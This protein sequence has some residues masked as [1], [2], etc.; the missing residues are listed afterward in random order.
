MLKIILMISVSIISIGLV[1]I[2]LA[3]SL[4]HSVLGQV[5]GVCLLCIFAY[6]Y[7]FIWFP[8]ALNKS[9]SLQLAVRIIYAA[10]D[11]AILEPS[12][13]YRVKTELNHSLKILSVVLDKNLHTIRNFNI[14]K[15]I[16][17]SSLEEAWR[18]FFLEAFSLIEKEIEDQAIQSW[19]FNK[20]RNKLNHDDC[21]RQVKMI[22]QP[23]LK[24]SKFF[25]LVEQ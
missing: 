5:T 18:Q 12:L 24:D 25:Y 6:H 9:M 16:R 11:E 20:I 2:N 14:L 19:T 22:L 10:V 1:S 7:L 17:K 4:H 13:K 3:S 23:F 21:S 8:R 15:L